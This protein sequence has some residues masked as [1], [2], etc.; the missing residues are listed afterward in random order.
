MVKPRKNS[1]RALGLEVVYDLRVRSLLGTS[2]HVL[3]RQLGVAQST[4]TRAANGD[5]HAAHPSR[6]EAHGR[7]D[8]CEDGGGRRDQEDADPHLPQ[9]GQQQWHHNHQQ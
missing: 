3:A 1:G 8:R 5:T 6:G 4:I 7:D 9:H 2:H